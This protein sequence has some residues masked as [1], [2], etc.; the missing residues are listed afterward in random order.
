MVGLKNTL[1]FKKIYYIVL[2]KIKEYIMHNQ[3]KFRRIFYF[4]HETDSS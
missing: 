2:I 4:K 1:N 3:F